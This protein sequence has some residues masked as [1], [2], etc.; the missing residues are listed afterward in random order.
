MHAVGKMTQQLVEKRLASCVRGYNIYNKV[1]TATVGKIFRYAGATE[2][3]YAVSVLKDGRIV[4]HF[5][6]RSRN[7]L[8]GILFAC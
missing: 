7:L 5:S 3:S 1:R 8:R 6:G 2:D 4:G